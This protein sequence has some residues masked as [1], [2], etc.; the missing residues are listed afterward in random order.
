MGVLNTATGSMRGG[1][2]FNAAL[3]AAG[4]IA[5][6]HAAHPRIVS[7]GRELTASAV[8]PSLID[9]HEFRPRTRPPDDPGPRRTLRERR[10]DSTRSGRDGARG[11]RPALRAARRRARAPRRA[12]A[13][14]RLRADAPLEAGG[15]DLPAV[16]MVGV[17][18]AI[19][20][21]VTPYILPPDSPNLRMCAKWP[22]TRSARAISIRTHAAS[23]VPRWRSPSRAPARIRARC[24]RRP[25]A[26]ATA[27]AE[28]PQDLISHAT[29][30]DWTIVMAL[31]DRSKGKR[32]GMSA[33]IVDRDTPGFVI[34]RR[35]PMIGG[36]STY[37]IVLENCRLPAAQL[38]PGRRR[39][40]ADAGPAREPAAGDGRLHR[41]RRARGGDAVRPC[42]AAHDLRRAARGTPGCP[43]VGRRRTHAD[44]RVPPHDL[45]A[46]ARVDAGQ[47]ARTQI[48]MV[49]V[50]ATEM[51][52][53]VIDHAMQTLGAMGMTKEM[54]LQQMA[55]EARLM[56]IFEARPRYTV[57]SSRSVQI[58]RPTVT[59]EP[60]V[61]YP[62]SRRS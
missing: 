18:E 46:A 59:M 62:A 23:R 8:P 19:G 54:P 21:T 57:G 30:A 25:C 34:E 41:P 36:L 24:P 52:S 61:G 17:N 13:T 33:F 10:T 43:V 4:A 5:L 12:L 50:F 53:S 14:A 60:C 51:A 37:E 42:E 26:T 11:R 38:L 22:T 20:A 45:Q 3:L 55:S 44:P 58:A 6:F 47:D 39:F 27:G 1:L 7:S 32:G 56:R 16:A 15:A 49:K 35:I 31:T 29:E 48:S 40:R 2:Y 9:P 28:R